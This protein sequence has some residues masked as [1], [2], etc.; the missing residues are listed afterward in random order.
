M[1]WLNDHHKIILHKFWIL[2]QQK[3][4]INNIYRNEYLE[5]LPD[6]IQ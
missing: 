5:K 2:Y 6:L 4:R 1:Q 3:N